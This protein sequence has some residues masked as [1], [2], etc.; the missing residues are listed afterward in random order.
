MST[1]E[2]SPCNSSQSQPIIRFQRVTVSRGYLLAY[3]PVLRYSRSYHITGPSGHAVPCQY[4]TSSTVWTTLSECRP[5]TR[6]AFSV[7]C[8]F[9]WIL[10]PFWICFLIF[11]FSFIW[12]KLAPHYLKPSTASCGPHVTRSYVVWRRVGNRPFTTNLLANMFTIYGLVLTFMKKFDLYEKFDFYENLRLLRTFL[13]L[14]K[15]FHFYECCQ[16][17]V[18]IYLVCI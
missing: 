3:I 4:V 18:S 5:V 8:R 10:F 6:P 14:L 9:L 15:F 7:I 17:V 11:R 12:N 2:R 1:C 13:L 16:C